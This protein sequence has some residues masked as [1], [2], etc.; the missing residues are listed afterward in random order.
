MKV[1]VIA[2][3]LGLTA[4]A[5]MADCA[6]HTPIT[7]AA[8]VDQTIITASVQTEA[9]TAAQDQMVPPVTTS[10]DSKAETIQN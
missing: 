3:A 7:A 8:D 2:A 4:S 9:H 10:D 6:G 5:A 1:L